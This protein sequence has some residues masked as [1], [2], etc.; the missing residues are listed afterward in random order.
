MGECFRLDAAGRFDKCMGVLQL[1]NTSF[2][3]RMF[4]RR[5]KDSETSMLIKVFYPQVDGE[6]TCHPSKRIKIE[7]AVYPH[8]SLGYG[9]V[10]WFI[11]PSLIRNSGSTTGLI[12]APNDL[13]SKFTQSVM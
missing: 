6:E 8:G 4:R 11:P 5:T 2:I 9:P 13:S 1:S 10:G 7:E 12:T 3:L